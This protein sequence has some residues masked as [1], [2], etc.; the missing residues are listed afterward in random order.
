MMDIY[1]GVVPFVMLQAATVI[2]CVIWPDIIL[3]LPR[4]IFGQ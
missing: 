2:A 4:V 1:R 3:Y